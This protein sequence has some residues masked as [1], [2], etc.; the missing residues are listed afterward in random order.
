MYDLVAKEAKLAAGNAGVLVEA[1][2]T[3]H[4]Q[5]RILRSQV[6]VRVMSC[7]AIVGRSGDLRLQVSLLMPSLPYSR[8]REGVMR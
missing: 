7:A 2:L 6:I 1:K 8:L 5:I 3:Q 4:N